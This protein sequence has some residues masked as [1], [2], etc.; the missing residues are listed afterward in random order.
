MGSVAD[1]KYNM[2]AKYLKVDTCQAQTYCN[3]LKLLNPKPSRGF[4]TGE[5]IKFIIP[6]VFLKKIDSQYYIIFNEDIIHA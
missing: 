4:F 3:I 1:H 6:D 2:I 5:G